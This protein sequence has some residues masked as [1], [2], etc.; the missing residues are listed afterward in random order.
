MPIPR[1]VLA[2]YR[3]LCRLSWSE[4]LPNVMDCLLWVLG[5]SSSVRCVVPGES[6]QRTRYT[7]SSKVWVSLLLKEMHTSFRFIVKTRIYSSWSHVLV[8]IWLRH[9]WAREN[10]MPLT[11]AFH[12]PWVQQAP[13]IWDSALKRRSTS[14]FVD[15]C[16]ETDFRASGFT[17]LLLVMRSTLWWGTRRSVCRALSIKSALFLIRP[18]RFSVNVELSLMQW[19]PRDLSKESSLS[20]MRRPRLGP[21]THVFASLMPGGGCW[22]WSSAVNSGPFLNQKPASTSC[23]T[24]RWGRVW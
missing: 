10:C 15:V 18:Q 23:F 19:M 22:A 1:R 8:Q 9:R 3:I 4:T 7:T 21:K 5:V 24:K 20:S 17:K 6:I 12:S 13:L 14:N 11:P 16:L 2:V